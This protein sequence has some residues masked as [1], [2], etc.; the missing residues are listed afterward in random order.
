MMWRFKTFYLNCYR[1][2]VDKI[3]KD[4]DGFVTEA[5]LQHWIQ[6]VQKKYVL[7]DTE[8]M[9][10]DHEVESDELKWE[11]YRQ[12]TYGYEYGKFCD[13]TNKLL[14]C[15]LLSTNAFLTNL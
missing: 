1:I 7:E 11:S 9:W 5:E 13:E 8:R 3:D 2:I 15:F 6:Y 14:I 4:H 10:K 12:R